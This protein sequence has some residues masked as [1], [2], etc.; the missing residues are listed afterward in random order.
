MM[1]A[2]LSVYLV[3][4]FVM[5]VNSGKPH[6]VLVILQTWFYHHVVPPNS[7]LLLCVHVRVVLYI[8]FAVYAKSI[9]MIMSS[10]TYPQLLSVFRFWNHEQAWLICKA[11]TPAHTANTLNVYSSTTHVVCTTLGPSF[12]ICTMKLSKHNIQPLII[13]VC[14]V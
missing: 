1:L 11:L 14:S 3:L 13:T 8:V 6:S 7:T 4:C 9:H 12:I 2:A 10:D 5:W